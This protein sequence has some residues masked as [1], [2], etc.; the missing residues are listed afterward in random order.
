MRRNENDMTF[1]PELMGKALITQCSLM[2]NICANPFFF[3]LQMNLFC[4][5]LCNV[6]F[7]SFLSYPI[8][9]L[10]RDAILTI[11]VLH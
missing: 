10:F 2:V 11:V 8:N 3:S 9:N 1:F 6:T 4:L 7:Q 5:N